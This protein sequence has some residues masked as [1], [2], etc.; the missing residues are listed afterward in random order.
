MQ[1]LLRVVVAVVVVTVAAA[2]AAVVPTITQITPFILLLF[3]DKPPKIKTKEGFSE[4][5]TTIIVPT[6]PSSQSW[7]LNY[8]R[9]NP[10]LSPL[11]PYPSLE[12]AAILTYSRLAMMD[13]A[14]SIADNNPLLPR[15]LSAPF[16]T[17][18]I[19][20]ASNS[21]NSLRLFHPTPVV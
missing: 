13:T 8:L 21:P 12:A 14:I 5:T 6:V 10:A 16:P 20:A 2:A 15:L 18:Q 17:M 1:S 3:P 11:F 4:Q 19:L 7:F 9:N